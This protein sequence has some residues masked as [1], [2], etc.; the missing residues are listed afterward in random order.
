MNLISTACLNL[1][2]LLFCAIRCADSFSFGIYRKPL[3]F[4]TQMAMSLEMREVLVK[5]QDHPQKYEV[6]LKATVSDANIV[7]WYISKVVDGFAVIEV[8]LEEVS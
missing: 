6:L 2:I 8:V 3:I 5:L 4:S 7:R 1:I